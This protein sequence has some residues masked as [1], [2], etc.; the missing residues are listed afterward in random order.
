MT[1]PQ[2]HPQASEPPLAVPLRPRR[3]PAAE[4]ES[5]LIFPVR[6]W[7]D[8][9]VEQLGFPV[10]DPYLETVWLPVVGPSVCCTMRLLGAW[11]TASPTGV[12]VNLCE[13]A[14]ALGL[15]QRLDSKHAPIRRTL[16]RMIRFGLADWT[17]TALHI[18]T[19]VP[20]VAQ[21]HLDRLSPRLQ[22]LHDQ[23]IRQRRPAAQPVT[24]PTEEAAR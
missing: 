14:E 4:I 2:P 7:N 18:R 6:R 13:L 23:L 19:V 21:R 16:T 11:V 8:P 22:R 1:N 10:R 17:G 24:T 5:P 15:G 20:P 3:Y 12:D 9:L